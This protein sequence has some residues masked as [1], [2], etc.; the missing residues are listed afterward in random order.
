MKRNSIE[1][2]RLRYYNLSSQLAQIDTAHLLSRFGSEETS[3]G[4]G[5]NHVLG[6]GSE[7]VFVKRVPVTDLEAENLFSTANHYSLPTYYNYG[8]GSAGFGPFRE[9]VANIKTTNWVLAGEIATFPLL[10]HYRLVPQSGERA[11]VD[12]DK[13]RSYVEYWGGNENIGRYMLDRAAA[14]QELVLFLEHFPHVL[15]PWLQEHPDRTDEMVDELVESA[16]FLRKK[17]IIHL[18]AHYYN[19]VTDGTRPYVTDFG[20]AL[21]RSFS[22]S[23][24]ERAFFKKHTYYDYGM[25]L[26]CLP[27]LLDGPYESL[28]EDQRRQ[29]SAVYCKGSTDQGQ[30]VWALFDNIKEIQA[31]GS[32]SQSHG[33]L[34]CLMKHRDAIKLTQSFYSGLRETKTHARFP[35]KKLRKLLTD[36]GITP[37]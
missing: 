31:S 12:M 16:D 19:I 7:K 2:R 11:P 17:R 1:Q 13:H 28:P 30:I 6:L 8:V 5:R 9:L 4:W 32:M 25:I 36:T 37:A 20:L 35:Q 27:F 26:C 10:Y 23:E 34:N 18:D 3:H 33:L 24:D 14:S 29:L 15:K 22:L 21:D